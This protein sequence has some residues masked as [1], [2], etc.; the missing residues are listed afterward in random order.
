MVAATIGIVSSPPCGSGAGAGMGHDHVDPEGHQLRRETRQT[1]E[2]ALGPAILDEKGFVFLVAELPE[3]VS[4]RADKRFVG[5]E[6]VRVRRF[7]TPSRPAEPPQRAAQ[8]RG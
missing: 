8:R 3:A 7:G 6:A 5:A 4:E 2:L 1:V